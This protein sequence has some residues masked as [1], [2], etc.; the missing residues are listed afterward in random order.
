MKAPIFWTPMRLTALGV[1]L[2]QEQD[3]EVS[4]CLCK[5]STLR[6]REEILYHSQGVTWSGI[7]A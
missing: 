3:G 7:R 6:G 1:V 5:S 4:Y 2:Q